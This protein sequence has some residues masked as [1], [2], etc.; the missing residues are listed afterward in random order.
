MNKRFVFTVS[1]VFAIALTAFMPARG[2]EM[3]SK[4]DKQFEMG[5]YKEAAQGYAQMINSESTDDIRCYEQLA[6]CYININK[7]FEAIET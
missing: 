3:P 2:Q 4:A 1:C 7:P 6:Q 5:M